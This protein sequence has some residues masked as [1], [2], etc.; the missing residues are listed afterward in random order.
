MR[1]LL[2]ERRIPGSNKQKPHR[3][4][5]TVF[6]VPPSRTAPPLRL[7][8]PH[9]R[10]I[11]F[12]LQADLACSWMAHEPIL[13]HETQ[14]SYSPPSSSFLGLSKRAAFLHVATC[15]SC[16]LFSSIYFWLLFQPDL[17]K[18]GFPTTPYSTF[19]SR[20]LEFS[21]SSRSA[22]FLV[23]NKIPPLS[24]FPFESY[25]KRQIKGCSGHLT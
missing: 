16:C 25:C 2:K 22:S 4:P 17:V 21:K 7:G 5:W 3:P 1:E 8:K 6:L 19:G 13:T 23:N 9:L 20:K 24:F 14:M 11:F 15:W 10:L 18:E 12:F